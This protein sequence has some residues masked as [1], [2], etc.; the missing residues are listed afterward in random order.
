MLKGLLSHNTVVKMISPFIYGGGLLLLYYIPVFFPMLVIL[1]T[2]LIFYLLNK[3]LAWFEKNAN[4]SRFDH[5]RQS[6]IYYILI[7]TLIIRAS[8]NSENVTFAAI[9]I[10]LTAIV[11]IV[12]NG[13]FLYRKKYFLAYLK[14][15]EA[16]KKSVNVKKRIKRVILSIVAIV[17]LWQ[18]IFHNDYWIYVGKDIFRDK[19]SSMVVHNLACGSDFDYG[20][21]SDKRFSENWR[22]QSKIYGFDYNDVKFTIEDVCPPRTDLAIETS[23]QY[24]FDGTDYYSDMD[25]KREG[26]KRIEVEKKIRDYQIKFLKRD[27][28]VFQE[29][30]KNEK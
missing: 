21:E 3:L 13:V 30:L 20:S 8:L 1:E 19:V 23:Y 29:D 14:N 25:E 24:L 17:V 12:M 27:F 26:K 28:S 10:G 22:E 5:I 2:F 9:A 4:P 11:A 15:P 7:L 6:S 18:I 16:F